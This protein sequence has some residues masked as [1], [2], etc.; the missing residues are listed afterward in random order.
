MIVTI[1]GTGYVGL[2]TGAC[3]AS[4]GH[5]VRA[6][7][8][9]EE[10]VGLIR[11]GQ[12]PF[13]EPGLEELLRDGL[14]SGRLSV[15]TSL[16][17][18]IQ[19]SDLSLIAVGT[20]A[21]GE[22]PDLSFLETAAAQI[23]EQLR[24][25]GG[26]H[27]VAVKSTVVPG[28]TRNIVQPILEITSGL[29]LGEFG[30][31]M[32]P[33]FLRE[34][35][36]VEDF[37]LPD[38]IVIGQADDRSGDVLDR[39]YRPYH[40]DKLR[41][42]L[43]EA[44]LTKYASNSLLS[45]L[46]SFGNELAGLCEATPGADLEAV[47]EALYLDRR[48]SPAGPVGSIRPEILSYLR[49]GIGFHSGGEPG[50][51]GPRGSGGKDR[52]A[53]G[54]GFQERNRRSA[55]LSSLGG[56]S[57]ARRSRCARA[58]LRS[59]RIPRS[60]C[61]RWSARP[62]RR[63]PGSRPAGRGCRSDH[64]RRPRLSHSRLGAVDGGHARPCPDRWPQRL[65]QCPIARGGPLLPHRRGIVS[66]DCAPRRHPAHGRHPGLRHRDGALIWTLTPTG[67]KR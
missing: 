24:T 46:I 49:A 51:S 16:A 56:S 14:A 65:A 55:Q 38:R 36:A 15:T 28:T 40:C 32:N 25:L 59:I 57:R 19:A 41:V 6:V 31:C 11:A 3:L 17:S 67:S 12:T 61:P 34:G 35:C 7:D 5:T 44:E 45:V 18:A 20:P 8:V 64:H 21:K 63:Q 9:A 53:A 37:R 33:E 10:R 29:L 23:G 30:L 50:R 39:L 66:P 42:S 43:E 22:D 52:R 13:Y 1:V 54:S 27:V 48:L 4:K 47:M 58:S 26:Y 60:R 62:L 2:V